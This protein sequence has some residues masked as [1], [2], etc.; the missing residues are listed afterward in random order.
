MDMAGNVY[1]WVNDWSS[2]DYYSVSPSRNPLG[3][4]SGEHRILRGGY[5]GDGLYGTHLRTAGRYGYVPDTT[6]SIF[7]FR[8]VA[9]P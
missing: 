4:T 9:S 3:P 1:E 8:C 2:L 6:L 7:G 5:W